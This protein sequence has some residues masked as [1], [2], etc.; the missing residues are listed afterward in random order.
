MSHSYNSRVAVAACPRLDNLL[1]CLSMNLT[2][3]AQQALLAALA[4]A[5]DKAEPNSITIVIE[6]LNR[7]DNPG[8]FLHTTG[9]AV[10]LIHALGRDNVKLMFDCYHVQISEGD[11]T[12]RIGTL[13]PLIHHIQI[14]AVPSRR[15]PDEGEIA[16]D[17][18]LPAIDAMGYRGFIGAEY[19]PT[20]AVEEGLS[21]MRR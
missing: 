10:E 19:R 3:E 2:E 17:R 1:A 15:E 18:L 4:Y 9:Q 14:A 12:R 8:Y 5:S 7:F 6:P 20:A 13:L 16:Y 21:W 11:L